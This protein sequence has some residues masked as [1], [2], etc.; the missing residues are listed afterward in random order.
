MVSG[1]FGRTP[2]R[3]GRFTR[4]LA[5]GAGLA[6]VRF[7]IASL[8][9]VAI[10]VLS[11]FAVRGKLL[12]SDAAFPWAIASLYAGAAAAVVATVATESR[13][14]NTP[15]R[16]GASVLAAALV[17]GTVWCGFRFGLYPP[18]LI[19]AATLAIPLAPFI[20]R[21]GPQRF[22]IFT[23][24]TTVGTV[25]AFLSVLL[26]VA[27]FSAI[28]EMIRFLFEV[29]LP[30]DAYEHIFATAFTLV[31][32]LFALG[33]IPL[34][35]DEAEPLFGD[36]RLISGVR[37][38]FDWVAMPLALITAVVLH[39][40]AAKILV[41]GSLPVGEI[42]WIVIF[43]ALLVL[44]LRVAADPFLA[45]ASLPTRWFAKSFA[46]MLV[47]PL[48]LVCVALW[49]RV[50]GQGLTLQRYYL[51]LGTLAAILVVALQLLPRIRGDTRWMMAVP[52]A[53][54]AL[55]AFGPWSVASSVGRSQAALIRAG[56]P[57][58]LSADAVA[59]LGD[60]RRVE[61]RS[62]IY[63]LDESGQ[64]DR[65]GPMMSPEDRNLLAAA[66]DS[67]P[68]DAVQVAFAAFGLS[69]PEPVVTAARSFTAAGEGVIDI[70][71]FDRAVG[72]RQVI[73][74]KALPAPQGPAGTTLPPQGV[75]MTLADG[76]LVVRIDSIDDRFDLAAAVA[77]LPDNTFASNPAD[78]AAPVVTLESR[79]GRK[80]KLVLGQMITEGEGAASTAKAAPGAP[81]NAG[82]AATST[83][84]PKL[85]SARLALFYRAADWQTAPANR[86]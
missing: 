49:L 3:F 57:E 27:G 64:I 24:W 21:A 42:G 72:E 28:L 5:E 30:A 10:A 75:D 4:S 46:V 45:G 71:G 12:P 80:I 2:E 78:L 41:V 7:P 51:G 47:V 85:V 53:L 74:G 50:D 83:M 65:L 67:R 58:P 23:F 33:R 43:F 73:E 76:E 18:A 13:R 38:L 22:W 9:I 32:P 25:L 8:A 34:D 60:R 26:F 69:R 81:A 15:W 66:L 59:R 1:A 52:V 79:S 44:S 86:N 39:L 19:A 14:L 48:A 82:D 16:F 40:Y 61:L 36:D 54:L 84:M 11:N 55:S 63:A 20:G 70:S 29:G 6:V 56:L 35:F 77:K 37:I 17:G 62:R 31:G 68:S